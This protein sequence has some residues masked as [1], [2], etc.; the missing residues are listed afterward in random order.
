MRKYHKTEL[1]SMFLF[2]IRGNSLVLT[3]PNALLSTLAA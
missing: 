1:L 3:S 2:Q